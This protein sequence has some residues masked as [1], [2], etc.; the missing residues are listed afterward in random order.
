MSTATTSKV[1]T[2]L[3]IGGGI[4]GPVVATALLKAGIQ[5]TV[6]E[7]HPTLAEGIGGGLA[8][9][10]NGLAALGLIGAGDTVRALAT[11]VTGTVM[12]IGG[13]AGR[14]PSL[15]DVEPLQIVGRGDLHRV[16]HDRAAES[17]VRFEYG[18]RQVGAIEGLDS[19]RPQ[20]RSAA[21]GQPARRHPPR[22]PQDP[23]PL[24]RGH[25]LG[26]PPANPAGRLTT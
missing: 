10:P 13:H 18:K 19:A 9:A 5:A 16:L 2:A 26:P 1:R 4:A 14:L 3:V 11:P 6:Y 21:P 15:A 8:L 20:R 12:A 24:R 7:A 22:L 23:H 25:C 17:G